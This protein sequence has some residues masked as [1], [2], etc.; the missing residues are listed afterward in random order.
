MKRWRFFD[1]CMNFSLFSF[2][3][4]KSF[5]SLVV[6][7]AANAG[8]LRLVLVSASNLKCPKGKGTSFFSL[9]FHFRIVARVS[10]ISQIPWKLQEKLI[11]IVKWAWVTKSTGQ[12]WSIAP[13]IP[14]GIPTCNFS[15]RIQTKMFYVSQ[16]LT[17]IIFHQMNFWAGRK[18]GFLQS[19]L[20]KGPLILVDL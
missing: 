12:V 18:C 1:F 9:F 5:F 7:Q 14:N 13:A 19:F 11:L 8:M 20:K 3:F 17:R 2:L 6:P 10:T 4:S 16:S 15:S